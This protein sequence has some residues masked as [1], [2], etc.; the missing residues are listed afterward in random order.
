MPV[1]QRNGSIRLHTRPEWTWRRK[2]GKGRTGERKRETKGE[3]GGGE[4]DGG[5][6]GGGC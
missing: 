5:D 4:G 3:T 1:S 6:V 2:W